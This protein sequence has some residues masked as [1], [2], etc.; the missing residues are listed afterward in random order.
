MP[1][2]PTFT[3]TSYLAL[4]PTTAAFWQYVSSPLLSH[5]LQ[6]VLS[7]S[8]N[9]AKRYTISS[10][11]TSFA[12]FQHVIGSIMSSSDDAAAEY[13]EWFL[14]NQLNLSSDR[15]NDRWSSVRDAMKESL[16]AL[17]EASLK[18]NRRKNVI[19]HP[20]VLEAREILHE[21][22]LDDQENGT[23]VVVNVKNGSHSPKP[24]AKRL[25]KQCFLDVEEH[26]LRS[27]FMAF[28]RDTPGPNGRCAVPTP[29]PVCPS[30]ILSLRVYHDGLLSVDSR[31]AFQP[32]AARTPTSKLSQPRDS[33]QAQLRNKRFPSPL[34]ARDSSVSYLERQF[35]EAMHIMPIRYRPHIEPDLELSRLLDSYDPDYDGS[36]SDEKADAISVSVSPKSR[37]GSVSSLQYAPPSPLEFP[38]KESAL[39][40]EHYIYT[41]PRSGAGSDVSEVSTIGKVTRK[42]SQF[43]W[44][45]DWETEN[46]DEF[47]REALKYSP[48]R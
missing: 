15:I 48:S 9:P 31:H 11:I 27:E 18:L 32:G 6:T 45:G 41:R 22:R 40:R 37:A 12:Q 19:L 25:A 2:I 1:A 42:N 24:L 10:I 36:F 47:Y 39:V 13:L 30:S 35:A 38:G 20:A 14:V 21:M 5:S 8:S 34:E 23:N 7:A 44:K 46:E 43:T 29:R 16:G 33:L 26:T 17:V 3:S 28:R 4:P